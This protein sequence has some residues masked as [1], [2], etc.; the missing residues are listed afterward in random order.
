[1]AKPQDE[2]DPDDEPVPRWVKLFALV[3]LVL[4]AA[5][6]V[7]HVLGGGLTHMPSDH[8]S[9]HGSARPADRASPDGSATPTNQVSSDGSAHAADHDSAHGSAR[10]GH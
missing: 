10:R 6:I 1:M 9:P 4:I 7:M 8:A 3:A 2:L 5:F